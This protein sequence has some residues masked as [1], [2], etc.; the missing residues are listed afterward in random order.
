MKVVLLFQCESLHACQLLAPLVETIRKKLNFFKI[1]T[2]FF[3]ILSLFSATKVAIWLF[4]TCQ[5]LSNALK[6]L[7]STK[8]LQELTNRVSEQ[9]PFSTSYLQLALALVCNSRVKKGK[10]LEN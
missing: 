9:V 1:V 5:K 6:S 3:F 4:I 8:S 2:G 10:N 7:K